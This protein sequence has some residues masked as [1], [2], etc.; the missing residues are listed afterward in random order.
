M[1]PMA[2]VIAA[3]LTVAQMT[4]GGMR[5]AP[6][7][8][9]HTL[10]VQARSE[11]LARWTEQ[12]A[13]QA[14]VKRDKLAALIGHESAFNTKARSRVGAIGAGQLYNPLYVRH[15]R[16]DCKLVPA[17]CEEAQFAWAAW[18]LRDS[19]RQCGT[20]LRAFGHYRTGRCVEGPRAHATLRFSH[21]IAWRLKHPSSRRL[22]APRLP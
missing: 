8:E 9:R 22:V 4:G 21:Q 14:G 2:M 18:A 17:S 20:Y 15:W 5:H 11:Q 7:L 13:D 10:G 6:H 12:A 3:L 1:S 19:L 16:A